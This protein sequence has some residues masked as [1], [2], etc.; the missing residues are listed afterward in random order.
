MRDLVDACRQHWFICP[1][2]PLDNIPQRWDFAGETLEVLIVAKR[3][4]AKHITGV[5]TL[6]RLQAEAD[7]IRLDRKST[8]RRERRSKKRP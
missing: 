3:N 4:E 1:T 6:A 7:G 8:F 2:C 5:A